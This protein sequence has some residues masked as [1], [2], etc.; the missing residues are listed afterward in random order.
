MII[1]I[2][3]YTTFVIY[4]TN[5]GVC[6]L[7]NED[8]DGRALICPWENNNG[9]HWS[10]PVT[11]LQ[12]TKVRPLPVLQII[13]IDCFLF[14]FCV[15]LN[16]MHFLIII[17]RVHTHTRIY[18]STLIVISRA[19][20]LLRTLLFMCQQWEQRF[21]CIYLSIA[22]CRFIII[23]IHKA[24]GQEISSFLV[25]LYCLLLFIHRNALSYVASRTRILMQFTAN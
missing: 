11:T 18:P 13:W 21:R 1:G 19:H 7:Y 20:E 10:S 17:H 3:K 2:N 14:S 16:E 8:L 23:C 25:Y 22:V 5:E 24:W 6:A 12:S 15:S 4:V 9:L